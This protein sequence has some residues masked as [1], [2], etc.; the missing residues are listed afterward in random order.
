MS[1]TK[2]TIVLVLV[3]SFVMLQ[4]VH[5]HDCYLAKFLGNRVV[6]PTRVVEAGGWNRENAH[7]LFIDRN[8]ACSIITRKA[9]HAFALKGNRCFDG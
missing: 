8:Y 3:L 2:T 1:A 4:W 5:K 9:N 7:V 6:C